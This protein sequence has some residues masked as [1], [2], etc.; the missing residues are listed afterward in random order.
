ML[1]GGGEPRTNSVAEELT[2]AQA[3]EL[4]AKLRALLAELRAPIAG[5]SDRTD[6]VDLDQPIGRL[7]RMDALQQQAMA[8]EQRRRVDLRRLQVEQALAAL[9]SDDYGA[10]RLCEEPIGYRR[11]SAKPESAFCVGCMGSIERGRGG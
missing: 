9:A 4:E 8:K 10:C 1:G 5:A 3:Q 7:S 6:T 11:L 2:S